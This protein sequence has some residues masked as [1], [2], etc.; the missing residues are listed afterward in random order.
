MQLLTYLDRKCPFL[1]VHSFRYGCM[2]YASNHIFNRSAYLWLIQT[3]LYWESIMSI[4][5]INSFESSW[6]CVAYLQY[7]KVWSNPCLI[8]I[9]VS[10]LK[11]WLHEVPLNSNYF[12][13]GECSWK[14]K[15][16][17]FFSSRQRVSTTHTNTQVHGL[18]HWQLLFS[19]T[20]L[21]TN[22]FLAWHS[23][24]SDLFYSFKT[25]VKRYNLT[26]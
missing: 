21:K 12:W 17:I 3:F 6:W 22:E 24:P 26:D 9:P 14:W 18:P 4:M 10:S 11:D 5:G 20:F 7:G 15:R 2:K 13:N 16:L 19:D 8:F 25:R 1:L 23:Q